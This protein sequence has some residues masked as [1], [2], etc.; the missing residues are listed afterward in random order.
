MLAVATCRLLFLS[1]TVGLFIYTNQLPN[2]Q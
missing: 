1:Y 2:I